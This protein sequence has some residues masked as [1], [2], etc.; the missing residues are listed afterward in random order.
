M[1]TTKKI[2]INASSDAIWQVF[3]HDFDNAHI[4]MASVPN[5]F[6]AN[7]GKQYE[8]ATS[9]GRICELDT[10]PNGVRVK[11]SFLAYDEKTKFC[12]VLVEFQNTPFGF[13][14]VQ[15]IADFELEEKSSD[16]CIVTFSVTSTL[17]PFAYLIYPIIKLGFP[18][19]VQQIVEE[20]KFYVEEGKPHPRK[21]K[22]M[23]KNK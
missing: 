9:K 3:A 7:N 10:K 1:K 13:P 12:S 4:W 19:F 20:L 22:M 16:E 8:G 21:I 18:F 5:S 2:I 14:L 6:G 17:K 11:E 23:T 15:N